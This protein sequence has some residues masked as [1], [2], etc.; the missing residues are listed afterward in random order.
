MWLKPA[1]DISMSIVM[2]TLR[3]FPRNERRSVFP[4]SPYLCEVNNALVVVIRTLDI[5]ILTLWCW[6]CRMH[7]PVLVILKKITAHIEALVMVIALMLPLRNI[8]WSCLKIVSVSQFTRRMLQTWTIVFLY[9]IWLL[10]HP[11]NTGFD[12]RSWWVLILW[13]LWYWSRPCS[14]V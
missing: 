11:K 1:I 13:A 8:S 2:Y 14:F 6:S 12:K 3:Q 10:D 4:I 9:L 5:A 7:L